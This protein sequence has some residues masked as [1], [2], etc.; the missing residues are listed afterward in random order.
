VIEVRP[1][2]KNEESVWLSLGGEVASGRLDS[3]A[4]TAALGR[5]D[6]RAFLLAF[7]GIRCVGRLRGRFLNPR[8]YYV[9][10]VTVPEPAGFREVASSLAAFLSN[11]FAEDDTEVLAWDREA[12]RPVNSALESAGFVVG[13]RKVFVERDLS[14]HAPRSKHELEFRSLAKLGED[15][16]LEI[17]TEASTGDPFEESSDRDPRGE[18]RE[19]RDYA[20][21]KFDPTWWSVAYAGGRPIGVL[22]PQEFADRDGE[23]TLFY[24]AVLPAE[25]GHGYGRLLHAEGLAFLARN[26]ITHYVGSTDTRNTPMLRVF[27]AN[28]CRV[29]GTQLFYK[30]LKR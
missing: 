27:E 3:N 29:T 25:R 15:R 30:A 24:V 10:D 7:D 2:R 12:S 23:G 8:L 22:L 26:G 1:L 4:F 18:F 20:G 9:A 13:R 5:E 21:K 28:G 16:F 11:S 19:L 6:E 17:M 14:D